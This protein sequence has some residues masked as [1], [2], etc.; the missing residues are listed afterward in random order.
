LFHKRD[1]SLGRALGLG[2]I[3]AET[4]LVSTLDGIQHPKTPGTEADTRRASA[5]AGENVGGSFGT[6]LRGL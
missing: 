3:G 1:D 6:A 2:L 5:E 4:G